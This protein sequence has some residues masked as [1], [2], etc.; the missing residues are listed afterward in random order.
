MIMN[1]AGIRGGGVGVD[2]VENS[3]ESDLWTS[4]VGGSDSVVV[5]LLL[6]MKL[7]QVIMAL[8]V[9]VGDRVEEVVLLE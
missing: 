3:F 9:T 6:L 2:I 7:S 8:Q 4:G 1:V 5:A